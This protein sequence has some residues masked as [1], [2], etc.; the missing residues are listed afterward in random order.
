MSWSFGASTNRYTA[1]FPCGALDPD[2]HFAVSNQFSMFA[3]A[4]YVEMVLVVL[5]LAR[6]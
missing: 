5:W 3:I 1:A 2:R 4:V 6:D